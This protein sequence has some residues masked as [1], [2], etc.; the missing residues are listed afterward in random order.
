[1]PFGKHKGKRLSQIPE[2]YL[3][4][5]YR[6]YKPLVLA[7]ERTLKVLTVEKRSEKIEVE[8]LFEEYQRKYPDNK[9]ITELKEDIINRFYSG[10]IFPPSQKSTRFLKT[11]A[12]SRRTPR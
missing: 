11:Y 9:I 10:K 12:K 4:W 2:D 1:M 7:I 5:F 6:E 3:S 8:I